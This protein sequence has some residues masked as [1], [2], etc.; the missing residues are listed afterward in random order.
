MALMGKQ[1]S[2][3][4]HITTMVDHRFDNILLSVYNKIY[5]VKLSCKLTFQPIIYKIHVYYLLN[6]V[7]YNF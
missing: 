5:K 1:C 2:Y 3:L 4:L 7:D 6:R